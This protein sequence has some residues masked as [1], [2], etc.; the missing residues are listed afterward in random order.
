MKLTNYHQAKWT[1]NKD[2]LEPLIFEKEKDEKTQSCDEDFS[3]ELDLPENLVREDFNLPELSEPEVVRHFTRL[4]EM[5]YG[6]DSGIYPLGS[7]TMKYNPKVSEELASLETASCI[8]PDQ[9]E[10]TVQGALEIIYRLEKLL[11]EITGMD[12]ISFLPSAG[13]HGEFLAMLIVR[14]FHKSN[15]EDDQRRE[16][17]VPDSAHGTNPA[18]AAMAGYKVV[19]V[20][21]DDR[22]RVKLE[23]LRSVI[24][25]Q[26]AALMLTN[27]NTLGLFENDIEDIVEIVHDAGALLFYDGANLN[28]IM[29]KVR[30]GDMGFDIAHMNLHK[31]FATP[32]GGGGPGSGPVG[33]K[34]NLVEFLPE[35][36]VGYDEEKDWYYL[37]ENDESSVGKVQAFH[38]N[39]GVLLKAYAYILLMGF[40]GLEEVSEASVLNANYI[41]SKLQDIE[42]YELK[43]GL[44]S[45]CKHETV[46]SAEP[47]KS[48]YNVNAKDVSKRLLD[49]GVHAPTYYFPPIVPEA[50]M[51]E[52]TE[53]E[54]RKEIDRFVEAMEEI[55][56][57]AE[58][59][60]E[61][62]R[63][64]P[65]RTAIER[66]DEVE[67]SRNPILT[68]KM[69]L[70]KGE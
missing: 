50:L 18:S 64:A 11:S 4:S 12:R 17:V 70:K 31:T 27:P 41:R 63:S 52:P 19:E 53:T 2:K 36:L 34:E 30:P 10:E 45:P 23:A 14:A 22:G 44:E 43:Y 49:Y 51:I 68:W 16:V 26:T 7:C 32:H 25:N 54:S 56:Q 55:T 6:I 69:H 57:D 8:H 1:E 66:L 47:L 42:G 40:S 38:G 5:N 35:P 21:S 67:A 60:P 61:K 33:V 46:F 15:D 39:F 62:L 48:E 59:N 65:H 13:A 20:P 29:G 37:E 24:S 3:E 9:S 58:E 28:G